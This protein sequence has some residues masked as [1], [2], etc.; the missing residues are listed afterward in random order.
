MQERF[1]HRPRF[2]PLSEMNNYLLGVCHKQSFLRVEV[3]V[4]RGEADVD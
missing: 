4:K 1:I 3:A 2:Q